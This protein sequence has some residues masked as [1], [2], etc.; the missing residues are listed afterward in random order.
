[1]PI[2]AGTADAVYASHVLEHLTREDFRIA[3]QT[4]A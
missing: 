4:F 2:A 3:L 1:L